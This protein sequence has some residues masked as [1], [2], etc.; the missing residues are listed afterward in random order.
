MIGAARAEGYF[1]GWKFDKIQ[2]ITVEDLLKGKDIKI[3]YG[4]EETTF[5]KA[6]K[7]MIRENDQVS[8]Y[9]D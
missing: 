9:N 2:I 7:K 5:T 1:K 3:L 8:L 4:M 6:S